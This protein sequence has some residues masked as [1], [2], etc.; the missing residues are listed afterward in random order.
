MININL[1]PREI[2]DKIRQ[3]KQ[4]ANVFSICLVAV[5]F[6]IVLG[7]LALAADRMLLEPSLA[8]VKEDIETNTAELTSFGTLE[9]TALFLNDRAKIANGIEQKRPLWSQI[10]QNLVN[11]VPQQIQFES[12]AADITS[13]PNFV[14]QGYAKTERD[15]I[16][17]KD[18]LDA[19]EFFNNLAFKSSTMEDKPAPTVTTP[20]VTPVAPTTTAEGTTTPA[21]APAPTPVI[22]QPTEKRLK[23][24]LEF[25]LEKYFLTEATKK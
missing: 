11:C 15:I 6:L 9:E 12:L 25:D 7:I 22:A 16:S 2:K 18:K 19:S 4:S 8:T 3:A 1:V 10:I 21:P 14:I 17:F 20:V 23:F 24:T 13:K 5:F